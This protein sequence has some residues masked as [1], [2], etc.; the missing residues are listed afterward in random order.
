MRLLEAKSEQKRNI[1][2][3]VSASQQGARKF[4]R[5]KASG[6]NDEISIGH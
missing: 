5:Q 4:P 6:A 1:G 3:A 2:A